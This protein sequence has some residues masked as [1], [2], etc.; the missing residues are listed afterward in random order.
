[1]IKL[2]RVVILTTR[3][4][5]D[6]WL[7]NNVAEVCNVEGIV[8][9]VGDR[10]KEFGMADVFRR[11]MRR[12]GILS[13]ANQAL[14]VM[15]RLLIESRKDKK[16]LAAIFTGR[17]H[18]YI[19]KRDVDILEVD[20]IN[21]E[22]VRAFIL[23]KSPDVVVVSG[24]ALLKEPIIESAKGRII[25]LHPGFAPQ[26]RGRYGAF[27]PIYN[28]EPQLVGATIHFIDRGIDTGPILTQG[29]V[30]FDP[31]DTLKAITYKQHKVGVDLLMK[32]LKEFETFAAQA[33]HKPECPSTNYYVP[34]LTHYL[35]A[36]RWLRGNTC[37]R[38]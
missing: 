8:L 36:R 14:L 4:P 30:D 3:L 38:A 28:K 24:T 26:Y 32:C 25:N 6:V 16:A 2:L 29:K 33:Y 27:W 34:G 5:E 11:R 12:F 1:M 20:D 21:S 17:S 9:P 18:E 23:S 35:K 15:Y 31:G 22:E 10:S 19:E 7:V 37:V 13:V